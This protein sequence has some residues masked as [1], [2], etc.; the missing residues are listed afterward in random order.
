MSG[1]NMTATRTM[2]LLPSYPQCTEKNTMPLKHDI[3]LQLI[4]SSDW[5]RLIRETVITDKE[6]AHATITSL[7][8]LWQLCCY[9]CAC[10]IDPRIIGFVYP[11]NM[12]MVLHCDQ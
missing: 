10:L 7:N 4:Q 1:A 3:V 2:V 11:S 12:F 6:E 5:E 8:I 9:I